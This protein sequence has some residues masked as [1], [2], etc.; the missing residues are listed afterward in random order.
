MRSRA[1]HRGDRAEFG[2]PSPGAPG[3]Q[4]HDRVGEHRR[5]QAELMAD[6]LLQQGHRIGEGAVG[7]D[8]AHPWVVRADADGDSPAHRIAEEPD[9]ERSQTFPD[10]V[11]NCNQVATLVGAQG[12]RGG[13]TAGRPA[14]PVDDDRE[15]SPAQG[16]TDPEDVADVTAIAPAH[17]HDGV[18][19][20]GQEP[21]DE[22]QPIVGPDLE[23]LVVKFEIGG[24]E[25]AGVAV[26]AGEPAE[27][28]PVDQAA[29]CPPTGRSG[30]DDAADQ[31]RPAHR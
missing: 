24:R 19:G 14:P 21:G 3:H 15:A 4:G 11:E 30:G 10:G 20:P 13:V 12:V 6:A 7:A 1:G 18:P 22:A 8:G 31:N 28:L 17:D 26:C 29:G 9:R 16:G 5:R 2:E 23:L 25:L 27:G